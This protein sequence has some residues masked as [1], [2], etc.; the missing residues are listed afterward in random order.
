MSINKKSSSDEI[1]NFLKQND[2]IKKENILSNFK[3]ENIK[4]NEILF[5]EADDFIQLGFKFYK[6]ITKTLEEIKNNQKEILLFNENIDQQSTTEAICHFLQNEIKLE[7]NVLKNFQDMNFQKL[8]ELNYENLKELGLKLGERRK[9]LKY[10]KSF[11]NIKEICINEITVNSTVEEVCLFLKKRFKL[12]EDSLKQIKISV[13]N[14][15]TFYKLVEDDFEEL[16][17][18][19]NDIQTSILDY[20]NKNKPKNEILVET[21]ENKIEENIIITNKEAIDEENTT[22]ENF[23]HYLLIDILEYETSEE[24]INKCPSNNLQEF[25]QLCEDM[26]INNEDNCAKIDFDQADEIKLKTATLWGTKEGLID[27]FEKRKMNKTLEYFNNEDK[28]ETSIIL[29]IKEDKSLAYIIIWPGKMNYIYKHY[30]EP[31]K[32]L[33]LSFVRI[34]FSLSDNCVFCLSE[35]QIKEF[36]FQATNALYNENAFQITVGEVKFNIDIEDYF[37]IEKNANIN[38]DPNEIDGNI[39]NIKLNGNSVFIYVQTNEK[40]DEEKSNKIPLKNVNYNFENIY[41]HETFDLN[42]GNF[43]RFLMRFNKYSNLIKEKKYIDL[44]KFKESRFKEIKSCYDK[45]FSKLSSIN[46]NNIKCE[47]CKK[48]KKI[49]KYISNKQIIPSFEK[50]EKE[51]VFLYNCKKHNFHVLH[52][53]CL[54]EEKKNNLIDCICNSYKFIIVDQEIKYDNIIDY[55]K[56]ELIKNNNKIINEKIEQNIKILKNKKIK[57]FNKNIKGLQTQIDYFINSNKNE[58]LNEDEVYNE[59]TESQLKLKK[60]IIA[61]I[62]EEFNKKLETISEWIE[63]IEVHPNENKTDLLF[64]YK[65]YKKYSPNTQVKL[66]TFYPYNNEEKYIL[67]FKDS[68]RWDEDEFENYFLNDNN[69][70]I[71][72]KKSE[73]S[74][75]IRLKKYNNLKFNSCYDY[76]KD[77]QILII[78]NKIELT[79]NFFNEQTH[80]FIEQINIYFLKT[81]GIKGFINQKWISNKIYIIPIKYNDLFLTSLFFHDNI[82]SLVKLEQNFEIL[83]DLNIAV[84]Y[85]DYNLN[86]LQ[87]LIY[88]KFLLI[89]YYK[90][91]WECD[92]YIIFSENS[93]EFF[94]KIESKQ[95]YFDIKEKNCKFSICKIKNDIILYYCYIKNNKIIIDSKK[96]STSLSSIEIENAS[97][98]N[99]KNDILNLKEGNCALNFYYHAFK[100]FPSI[101]ALQYNYIKSNK[102]INKYF[103]LSFPENIKNFEN[104][105]NELKKRCINER[106]LDIDDLNYEFKGIY[107]TKKIKDQLGLG[108]LI[109]KFI[110]VIPLQLAKIKNY[111]FKAMSNG[112][113]IKTKDLY[114]KYLKNEISIKEKA[115]YIN[116][117]IKNSIFNYYDIPVIVLVF[118]GVQS[119]GKSTLSNEISLSF[120]NVSGMRCTEGIWMAVSL[121]KGIKEDKECNKNCSYCSKNKCY[122]LEHSIEIK[123][124]C[125]SCACKENCCLFMGEANLKTNQNFCKKRCALPKGHSKEIQHICEISPYNHGFIC[126]SLD[127][128]GLGTFERSLEQDIDLAMIGAAMGNSIILR[129]DK[130][131]DRFL[132]SRLANWAEGSKNINSTNSQN[133]FGGNLIFCQKDVLN[134]HTED[135]KREFNKQINESVKNWLKFEKERKIRQLNLKKTPIYGIFSKYINSPTPI[136]NQNQ[137]HNFLRNKL[138]HLLIKDVLIQKSL[139]K[140]RT[141]CEFMESL[142]NILAIVDIHDYNVLDSIA[143]DNLKDYIMENKNKAIDI[144]GIYKNDER[145]EYDSFETFENDLKSNLEMLKYSYISNKEQKIEETLVFEIN[146]KNIESKNLKINHDDLLLKIKLKPYNSKDKGCLSPKLIGRRKN[147]KINEEEP[148]E[149]NI[150]NIKGKYNSNKNLIYKMNKKSGF[151]HILKIEGIRDFGLLLLIPFEYKEIF[152][153]ED[154]RNKL[155]GIWIKISKEINLTIPE[156]IDNFDLFINEIVN[157]RE[158]NIKNWITNLTSSF[159]NE[160]INFFKNLNSSLKEKWKICKENCSFC[161]YKCTKILGHPNEH[162]C[163]FDHLCHE[164]CQTCQIINCEESENCDNMCHN[165]RAGHDKEPHSCSHIHYC[166]KICSKN[167]LRGCYKK[168][169]LEYGH[170]GKCFCKDIHFCDK[171]CIYKD[172]SEGCEKECCLEF[173]HNGDHICSSK[174]HKCKLECSLKNLSKGCI[175]NG[176]CSLNLPH[177]MENHNCGGNHKCIEKCNLMNKSE[178]CGIECVLPYGHLCDHICNNIHKCKGICYLSEKSRGCKNKCSLNY[179]HE[180]PHNCNEKHYCN[181]DCYYFK[182][183]K[184]CIEKK[185]SLV[186]GH[187]GNCNCGAEKHF[188]SQ[189]C[190]VEQCKNDCKLLCEHEAELL[191]DCKEFH[192]CPKT[193]SLKINSKKDSCDGFCKKELGHEGECFCKI[194]KEKH[195]CN[196]ICKQCNIPCK[197]I[198]NHAGDCICCGCTCDKYCIYKDNSHNCKQKCKKLLGHEGSHICEVINHLCKE[199]CIYEEKTREKNGGCLKYCSFPIDHEDTTIHFCGIEKNKHICSG[200]CHL[201]NKSLKDSCGQFC[202][203]PIEHEG[204]CQCQYSLEKHKCNKECSLN[205][206]KG[207]KIFCSLSTNHEG[208]CLCS[209]GEDGHLCDKVC[210]Y[211]KNTRIGCKGRCILK[212]NH[213][214]EQ[215]CICSNK[216]N[217]HIHKGECYLKTKSRQGCSIDCKLSVDHEGNCV[218]ENATSLHICN[219][220]CNYINKSFEGSCHKECINQADHPGEHICSSKKHECKE[221]CKYKDKSKDGCLG[222]CFKDVEHKDTYFS[223]IFSPEHVCKNSKEKHICNKICEL[224]DK[225]REGCKGVCDKAIEHSGSHLCNSKNHICKEQCYYYDKCSK[226]CHKMCVKNAGHLDKHECDI[227]KHFCS[228]VCYLNKVTR[229][230]SL[231]CSLLCDHDKLCICKKKYNEHLCNAKCLLCDDYCCYEYKHDGP[232]LC[233]KEHDCNKFCN[234]SGYCEIKTNNIIGRKLTY[235]LQNKR[236]KIE[237]QVTT[238]QIFNRKRCILKIPKGCIEH[239][240]KHKCDLIK[241]K[242][243]FK[244]RQCERLCELE[245]GHTS[246]HYCKHGHC[247]NSEIQTE[248]KSVDIVFNEKSFEFK[249]KEKA[250]MFTCHDYCKQQRRGHVHRIS[251][252]DIMNL[253]INLQNEN[254]KKLNKY[255]YECKCEFFWKIILGFRFETEFNNDLI[256]EFN[257]CRFKCSYCEKFGD[258]TFCELELW[259]RE[260]NHIFSCSHA[261]LVPYHT[262]FIID[263]SDSMGTNDITPSNKKLYKNQDFNNRLGCVIQVLNNYI[264][265]R[266]DI[267][268]ED[269]FSLISFSTGADICFRDYNQESYQDYDF[270]EECM[271][272]FQSPKGST[273]FKKGFEEAEKILLE[274]NKENY[275]PIIILLSDGDDDKPNETIEYVKTVSIFLIIKNNIL[276]I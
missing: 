101:G 182:I 275:N 1:C 267:N 69:S 16:H 8:K 81:N 233:D 123:C 264:K 93:D 119:I 18:F 271:E 194:D 204:P 179:G 108:S 218:C 248:E 165:K 36:D 2:F 172:F 269:V 136:F 60:S 131:I 127:F 64:T 32:S 237:F 160:N 24:D 5:L 10:M 29:A 12:D 224:K 138:I 41:F 28:I 260:K 222:H 116:F 154:I 78:I 232:H 220:P 200:T 219:Q 183:S 256:S 47:L 121:F 23:K 95:N 39:T 67:K 57:N 129:V 68:K 43:F 242:C 266:L 22:E 142:K 76:D 120:F 98:N 212:Y 206:I 176:I 211:L 128:E 195:I 13:I 125:S 17:I 7:E 253:G 3:K 151:K 52:M 265:K 70:G 247:K 187:S 226:E 49:E 109:I 87:Y 198:V 40:I 162:N 117:G 254:I 150:H 90:E 33:L 238:E 66:F 77:N 54:S 244:C 86:E 88:K 124:I 79:D 251:S 196:K 164:K 209:V 74:F 89:F 178:N 167:Q 223:F 235:N 30:D 249:N 42:E 174:E 171:F 245:F 135:I 145:K 26:K 180:Y 85:K 115:D 161:Y 132:S 177:S 99:E 15:E 156:I 19:D 163:G 259:H 227:K 80:D 215:L 20:I 148:K 59:T 159:N 147:L 58:I 153:L 273:N 73:N 62:N 137:F 240:Q 27:F 188:C 246:L 105:F 170:K 106:G 217:E 110:E 31:Q 261:K 84:N 122:L 205:N 190:S 149:T 276:I 82:I 155:F 228:K 61:Q 37:K 181:N 225:S 191:H 94:K 56:A 186:Y 44:Q 250:I 35:K 100:K 193:C 239:K 157:R 152:S 75:E 189:K 102:K 97:K 134:E 168:C 184:S 96:V 113:D 126:V 103:Y 92:V 272:L 25:I 46:F 34:G 71:L 262:I 140:F 111:Y 53:T 51:K 236:Q 243:G 130:T 143:I 230:C 45:I 50:E 221:P 169:R 207:C 173:E 65:I 114:N 234:Q 241:H 144:L 252:N 104:Y 274:I 83:Y 201:Y 213:S 216:I 270:I 72:V 229:F 208:N 107:K 231:E 146:C 257:K 133:Y 214:K 199:K 91:I 63:F 141:G 14:G 38:F 197:L 48:D 6:K 202:N 175:N 139:P 255:T 268:K 192:K 112:K 158:R 21:T 203:K 263:K 185:C 166:Q 55:I 118:M 258:N 9:L 11:D 4:G 210:H